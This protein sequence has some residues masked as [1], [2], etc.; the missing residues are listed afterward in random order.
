MTQKM[1]KFDPIGADFIQNSSYTHMAPTPESLGAEPPEYLPSIADESQLIP[2]P[3]PQSIPLGHTDLRNV[4][5]QRRS[6]R[7]YDENAQLTLEELS[8]L[9]WMTQGIVHL[10]EK[11]GRTLRTVPSAGAR[12]PFE[13]YLA[14]RRAENLGTSY[15]TLFSTLCL[16]LS[17]KESNISCTGE[18]A[19]RQTMCTPARRPLFAVLF[20]ARVTDT[21]H[22]PTYLFLDAGH[23]CQ[24]CAAEAI[25]YGVCAIGAF[26]DEQVN[27]LELT[28]KSICGL[29]GTLGKKLNSPHA[30]QCRFVILISADGGG[31]LT[32][33]LP[34]T[35]H[36]TPYGDYFVQVIA[37][38]CCVY[39]CR[40]GES[41]HA[42]A[43]CY[44][45]FSTPANDQFRHLRRLGRF[46]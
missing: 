6:V 36:P 28:V 20:T 4:I 11:T 42:G 27:N 22:A 21:E 25:D 43:S 34:S 40:L 46:S 30:V 41:F 29:Y 15:I 17:S 19:G 18:A 2:L 45:C 9:L 1:P 31:S 39:A 26:N 37:D 8:Y 12:H 5:E 13:T 33:T 3:E 32:N 7:R 44:R 10:S 16:R 14:L 24:N 23:I 38:S 35:L